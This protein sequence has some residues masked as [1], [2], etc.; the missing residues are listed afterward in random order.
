MTRRRTGFTLVELLAATALFAVLGTMLF[1]IV[2]GAMDIW[3]IGER[4]R[5]LHDRATAAMD[6]MVEDLRA[7][8]P[9][10]PGAAEQDARFLL[11]LREEDRDR[12]GK[13][14]LRVPVLRFSRLC[15]EERS[16][17][18]LRRAGDVAGA[19][20]SVTVLTGQDPSELRPTGGLAE[21]LYTLALLPGHELPSLVRRFRAP[22]GGEGSLLEADLVEQPDRLLAGAVPLADGVLH[23]GV[24]CWAPH[25]TRWDADPSEPG[26]EALAGWDSTRGLFPAS[27]TG[28]PYGKGPASLFDGRDDMVPRHVRLTLVLDEREGGGSGGGRLADP[29]TEEA[30]QLE[31]ASTGFLRDQ[32]A[33]DH[34]LVG[35]EWMRVVSREGRVLTVERAARGTPAAPHESGSAVRAGRTFE[36]VVS[37]PASREDWNP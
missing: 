3:S 33:P 31:L 28:F 2:R 24:A 15:H 11:S 29:M 37:L 18:W 13:T 26:G 36:R 20:G 4:N 9:G 22:L 23:L 17:A 5:E 21:S 8:W 27:D 12:D 30:R 35:Q 10:H 14:D 32:E 1:Q 34:V 16:L 6:V 19:Q 25:T 7:V